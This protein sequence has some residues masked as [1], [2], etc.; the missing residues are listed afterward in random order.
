MRT[1]DPRRRSRPLSG[2]ASGRPQVIDVSIQEC[3]LVSNMGAHW[4]FAREHK[5]RGTR[6]G[7]RLGATREIWRCQ[8]GWVSFGLRGGVARAPT[9]WKMTKILESEG[10]STPAWSERDWDAFNQNELSEQEIREIEAPL[11]AYFS[12]HSMLELYEMAAADNLLLATCNSPRE[13]LGSSQLAAREMFGKLGE[14]DC[15]PTRF[16]LVTSVDGG[17]E[18]LDAK[19]PA[20]KLATDPPPEWSLRPVRAASGGRAWE[21]TRILELG[22]GAAGPIASRYFAEHGAT[23]IRIESRS[24]PEFLRTMAVAMR[25]PFGLE[26]SPI[27]GALNV[28]KQSIALDLKN[29]EG[30]AVAKRLM[31]W[32]DLV[33]EN[34]APKAMRGFG[35]DYQTMAAEHPDLVMVSACMNG[36]TGPHRNYPGFGSQGS[37]LG[38][39]TLLT[40]YPDREPVG[41]YGTI[42]DSLAPRFCA[43]AMAAALL[44]HRRVGKGVHVD[45]SQVEAAQY[46]LSPWL[47]DH[48]VNGKSIEGM[49]NRSPRTAPHGAF[50]CRGDD[51]WVAVAVWSDE[52]WAQLA[53]IIG[54]E[55]PSLASL[56]A[57][58]ER[59]DEVET[60]LAAL[61]LTAHAGRG[62]R[63]APDTRNRGGSGTGLAGRLRRS[64]ARGTRSFR[65]PRPSPPRRLLVSAQRL[66]VERRASELR[67]PHTDVG[68]AQ[69]FHPA[70]GVG[71]ERPGDRR[72]RG[73]RRRRVRGLSPGPTGSASRP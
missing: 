54:L 22:S 70:R 44:Y 37:A 13:I 65:A 11:E 59:V 35:L 7:A 27:F 56:P 10:L 68:R 34:F 73:E 60:A 25:S 51:R 31:G 8:D 72:P 45:L 19:R 57:R 49:G 5:D 23:V 61:D 33:L 52:E 29:P 3:V 58:M 55:D 30:V 28:G 39:F 50:P 9:Y 24:R 15:F 38:G 43:T 14:V 26:G 48:A 32:A 46:A 36:Q 2:L 18:P 71:N 63:A 69:P 47:L 53:S 64:P 12:R 17:V 67:A 16:A 66:S 20:P 62:L 41:P 21:G 40:G 1:S 42:S 4:E 6:I